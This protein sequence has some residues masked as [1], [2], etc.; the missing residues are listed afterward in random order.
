M[1]FIFV[2]CISCLSKNIEILENNR[3][4]KMENNP[5]LKKPPI[6]DL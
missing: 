2:T 3:R 4:N 1:F 5:I 6:G